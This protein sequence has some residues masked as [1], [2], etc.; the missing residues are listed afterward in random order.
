MITFYDKVWREAD[1]DG[2]NAEKEK[3][4]VYDISFSWNKYIAEVQKEED[5]GKPGDG[6]NSS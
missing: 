6:I 4:L 1:D 3:Q 5:G 2:D